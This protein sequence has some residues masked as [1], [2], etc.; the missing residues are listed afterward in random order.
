MVELRHVGTCLSAPKG[1]LIG[2]SDIMVQMSAG[3]LRLYSV[4][5]SDGGALV[6]D[7]SAA[8]TVLDQ[9]RFPSASAGLDAPRQ[10]V[11]ITLNGVPSLVSV[12]QYGTSLDVFP[13]TSTG[14]L[15]AP[16]SLAMRGTGV[17]PGATLA[18]ESLQIGGGQVFALA[19]R[20]AEG[21]SLWRDI[22]GN[23]LQRIE[24]SAAAQILPAGGIVALAAKTIA[25]QSYLYALSAED[26]GLIAYRVDAAGSLSVAG[27]IDDRDGL[28]ICQGSKLELVTVAGVDYALVG[29]AGSS[30]LAVVAL[31]ADGAM[32]M[33]DHAMDERNTRF[34]G[35]SEMATISVN[36]Q[37][38]IAVAGSDDGVSLLTLLPG[39]RLVHLATVADAIDTALTN[40]SGLALAAQNGGLDLFVAGGTQTAEGSGISQFHVDLGQIGMTATASNAGGTVTGTAGRDQIIGGTGNDRIIGGAGDDILVDGAGSDTLV[41]GAGRDIFVLTA[42]GQTDVIADFEP[43]IDRLDM[44]ELGRFYT[45]DAIGFTSTATGGSFSFGSERVIVNTASGRP[46]LAQELTIEDL[47]DLTH[48]IATPVNEGACDKRGGLGADFLDGRA[49]ADTLIGAGGADTLMGGGGNDLL[50]GGS[51]DPAFDPQAA[52]IARLY[53]ATLNRAPDIGGLCDWTHR[54]TSHERTLEQVVSGFVN[55]KEFRATYGNTDN[56]AFTTM[57]YYNVLGREPDAGGLANWVNL[58]NSGARSREQVVMGFSESLE[59]RNK[60]AV[61]VLAYSKEGLQASFSDDVY[62]LYHATLDRDPDRG[63]FETWTQRLAEGRSYESAVS[64]FVNSKEFRATYGATSDKGFV[65]LLYNN[66]LKRAPDAEGLAHWT[67]QLSSGSL[68]RDQ[69]VQR[70]S[71]S[72]EFVITSKAPLADWMHSLGTDDVIDGGAGNNVM[73]GGLF[74]DSFVFHASGSSHDTV[75]GFE[76]WDRLSFDG[77]GYQTPSEA[78]SH[79]Q[80][81]SGGVTFS[82]QGHTIR[83]L[84][85]TMADMTDHVFLF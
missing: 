14:L 7:T 1:Y 47:R 43:G 73:A 84:H 9:E 20:Q 39:G 17:T 31:G 33:T 54:L 24:Q 48:L 52:Q 55:S 65:T 46:L 45:L 16:Y 81:D 49:G 75:Q 13:L 6:L 53:Q 30:S 69:V 77:F 58:L 10:L 60:T 40:P 22:G 32:Q 44:G 42:D 57:L 50:L 85:S 61:D 70:F 64:G 15:G 36:G 38:Y 71:Q 34:G 3:N 56:S 5:G 74:S 83:F 4:C 28:S 19:S 63:G 68:T 21:L 62:R 27:R 35:L 51:S 11:S 41:G 37:T 59:F 79:M 66:V 23:Q 26:L 18:I 25:G 2:L 76:A 80:Q 67:S 78:R 72:K 12:G 29:A 82:D 8:M